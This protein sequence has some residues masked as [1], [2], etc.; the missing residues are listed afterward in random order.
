MRVKIH[1]FEENDILGMF[2]YYN[3]S[4]IKEMIKNYK[5]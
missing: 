5:V 4:L 2:N 3:L 1:N